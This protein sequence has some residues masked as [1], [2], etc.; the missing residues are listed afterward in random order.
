MKRHKPDVLSIT[1]KDHHAPALTFH[2]DGQE[3]FRVTPDRRLVVAA[4]VDMDAA[5]AAFVEAVNRW[6]RPTTGAD[7]EQ[8]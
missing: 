7:D 8:V 5:A 2:L 6:L 3:V 1:N 4:D